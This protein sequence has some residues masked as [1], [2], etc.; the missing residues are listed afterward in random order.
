MNTTKEKEIFF[1]T[2]PPLSTLFP[3]VYTYTPHDPPHTQCI[4]AQEH[5]ELSKR[6]T[7][8]LCCEETIS[9]E[10]LIPGAAQPQSITTAQGPPC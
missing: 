7:A 1:K 3:S 5:L 8:W 9:G 10:S 6:R 2:K 4:P